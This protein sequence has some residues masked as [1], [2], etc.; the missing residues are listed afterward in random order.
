MY[1]IELFC[2]SDLIVSECGVEEDV[3]MSVW[4]LFWLNKKKKKKKNGN[5]ELP[6]WK[7]KNKSRAERFEIAICD[8]ATTSIKT[9]TKFTR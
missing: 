9:E 4:T 3:Q 1:V 8:T 2:K 5:R 7:K 6:N